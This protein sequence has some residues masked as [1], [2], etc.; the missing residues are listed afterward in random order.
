MIDAMVSFNLEGVD[1]PQK[2]CL[3]SEIERSLQPFAT[4]LQAFVGG[5]QIK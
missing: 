2:P 4:E 1:W 5:I 3:L